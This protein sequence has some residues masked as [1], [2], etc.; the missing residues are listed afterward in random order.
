MGGNAAAEA[1]PWQLVRLRAM[2]CA[3]EAH[4]SA[5]GHRPAWRRTLTLTLALA[6]SLS[7]SLS[8]SLTLTLTLSLTH[9]PLRVF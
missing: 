5:V 3:A 1:A 8:L 6:L 4:S 2:L 7:L 9:R